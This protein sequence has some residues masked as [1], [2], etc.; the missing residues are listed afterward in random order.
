MVSKVFKVNDKVRSLVAEHPTTIQEADKNEEKML[1]YIQKKPVSATTACVFMLWLTILVIVAMR[2]I[3][4]EVERINLSTADIHELIL[5]MTNVTLSPMMTNKTAWVVHNLE[6]PPI[7]LKRQKLLRHWLNQVSINNNKTINGTSNL[8]NPS[9]QYLSFKRKLSLLNVEHTANKQTNKTSNTTSMLIHATSSE[10]IKH[11]NQTTHTK[12]TNQTN[13]DGSAR[14]RWSK[15]FQLIQSDLKKL[16]KKTKSNWH[17]QKEKSIPDLLQN[18]IGPIS[19]YNDT[20]K[21]NE[22]LK[23]NLRYKFQ[24]SFYDKQSLKKNTVRTGLVISDK[25]NPRVVREAIG[26]VADYDGGDPD[27]GQ[28]NDD[29]DWMFNFGHRFHDDENG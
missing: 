1:R 20:V 13:H 10:E 28:D 19:Q 18:E 15:Y 25:T 3:D 6:L 8:V 11:P 12:Q 23:K 4:L 29:N 16:E 14:K 22:T 17:Q 24:L 27:P 5:A 7:D 9:K 21:Q 2:T 26:P